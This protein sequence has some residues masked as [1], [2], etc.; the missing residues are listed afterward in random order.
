LTN[1]VEFYGER[2]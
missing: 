1:V 2:A